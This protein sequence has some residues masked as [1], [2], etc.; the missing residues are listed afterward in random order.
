MIAV[1]TSHIPEYGNL[2][3]NDGANDGNDTVLP[4]DKSITAQKYS[5]IMKQL[6]G[7]W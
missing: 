1:L 5:I 3:G 2:G 7:V 6:Q 4:R